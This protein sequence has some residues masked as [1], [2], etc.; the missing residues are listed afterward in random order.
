MINA[1][2]VGLGGFIGSIGR[3][4]IGLLVKQLSNNHWFPF[5]TMTVNVVGCFMIGLISSI[6][7]A[8][9]ILNHQLKL[10]LIVGV[11]GGFTTFSSFGLETIHLVKSTQSVG[12]ILNVVG[13]VFLCITA[14]WIGHHVGSSVI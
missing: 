8:K 3:Y 10:F 13:S 12:A 4:G 5:G 6:L 2:Y 1:L 9:G 14:A 7:L 11:L